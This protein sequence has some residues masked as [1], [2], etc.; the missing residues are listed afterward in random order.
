MTV[1]TMAQF[2]RFAEVCVRYGVIHKDMA[3]PD[4]YRLSPLFLAIVDSNIRQ[5]KP[6]RSLLTICITQYAPEA[7]LHEGAIMSSMALVFLKFDRPTIFKKVCEDL[8]E[9]AK[10][11]GPSKTTYADMERELKT[12]EDLR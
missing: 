7:S 12:D 9:Y 8:D 4:S 10:Q 3:S 6:I 11:A 1:P 2:E 5:Q